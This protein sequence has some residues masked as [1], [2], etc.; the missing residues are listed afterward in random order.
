[1]VRQTA[2]GKCGA[3]AGGGTE[4]ARA[5]GLKKPVAVG[6]LGGAGRKEARVGAHSILHLS[7]CVCRCLFRIRIVSSQ[8]SKPCRFVI[9]ARTVELSQ[10][11]DVHVRVPSLAKHVRT[12]FKE[13]SIYYSMWHGM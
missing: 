4:N 11:R 12:A 7:V 5:R 2:G 10:I 13:G 6:E 8:Y 9:N 3:G 1:M